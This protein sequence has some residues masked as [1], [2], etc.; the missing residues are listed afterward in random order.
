MD[1][2]DWILL[3][4]Y[5]HQPAQGRV[6]AHQHRRRFQ[7]C[8]C[9]IGGRQRQQ[10][11]QR[12]FS[13]LQLYVLRDSMRRCLTPLLTL[14]IISTSLIAEEVLVVIGHNSLQKV[15]LATVQR[16]YNGRIVSLNQQS[17]MPLNLQPGDPVRQQFLSSVLGQT[18][19]QYTGY[20][21]VR[22]YVGK[23]APPQEVA[24]LEEIIRIIESTPGALGYIPLS[25][26][27]PWANVIFR[28]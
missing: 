3:P 24:S 19:E 17:A 2:G 15:D 9:T 16:L 18:E 14:W 12:F 4:D 20:W 22:R 28:R 23:G 10:T 7:L 6:V 26:A 27:P 5:S 8:G 11:D 13:L 1:R 25:K 21:L